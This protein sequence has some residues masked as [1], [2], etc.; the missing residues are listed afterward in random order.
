MHSIFTFLNILNIPIESFTFTFPLH[1]VTAHFFLVMEISDRTSLQ[2]IGASV[3]MEHA[4]APRA[5]MAAVAW[6]Q[7]LPFPVSATLRSQVGGL[8]MAFNDNSTFFAFM[9]DFTT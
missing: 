2:V 9:Q 3:R 8:G 6:K 4:A 7:T 5:S 1:L